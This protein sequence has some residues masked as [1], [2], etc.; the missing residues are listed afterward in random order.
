MPLPD[1]EEPRHD[2][3]GRKPDPNDSLEKLLHWA[4]GNFVV[5]SLSLLAWKAC[6]QAMP[7]RCQALGN[8]AATVI[9]LVYPV[10]ASW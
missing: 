3:P 7:I 2:Q 8:N 9:S 4:I 6:T 1:Q 10:H 5:S